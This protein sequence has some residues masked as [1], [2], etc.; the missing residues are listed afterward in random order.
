MSDGK[1]KN[2]D[3][4]VCPYCG[5]IFNKDEECNK[6]ICFHCKKEFNFCC[7]SKRSPV[8]AHGNHYHRP[9]CMFNST[10]HTLRIRKGECFNLFK[11]DC[12]EC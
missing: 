8:M 5:S 3:V 4:G 1:G 9:S 7:S 2:D 10:D 11:K 6:V 12:E